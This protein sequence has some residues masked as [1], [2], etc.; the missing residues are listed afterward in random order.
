MA[1]LASI[2]WSQRLLKEAEDL[3]V[4]VMETRKRVLGDKHPDTLGA[5]HNL[6]FMLKSQSRDQDAL[7]LLRTCVRMRT[8]VLGGQHPDTESSL[9]TL[10]EWE[11][12]NVELG[13]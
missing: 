2:F 8:Q 12:E 10:T 6:A 1:N 9:E 3:E 5:M 7:I 13:H 4:R 11:M